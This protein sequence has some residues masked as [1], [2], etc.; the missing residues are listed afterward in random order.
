MVVCNLNNKKCIAKIGSEKI[1]D[2]KVDLP[3]MAEIV[4]MEIG[5]TSAILP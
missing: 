5:T 1:L 2:L 3:V 4:A